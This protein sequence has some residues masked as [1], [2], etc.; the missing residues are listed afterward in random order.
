MSK[1]SIETAKNT[2]VNKIIQWLTESK[3]YMI[4]YISM[5]SIIF[6]RVY[7][8]QTRRSH[9]Y[10]PVVIRALSPIAIPLFGRK[11]IKFL[12]GAIFQIKLK[13]KT[14]RLFHGLCLFCV[15]YIKEFDAQNM[16]HLN[17]ESMIKDTI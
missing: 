8:F 12:V 13:M 11:E 14:L 9:Y 17:T 10:G 7:F 2:L 4:G 16:S 6:S 1:I 15:N 5:L 3:Y